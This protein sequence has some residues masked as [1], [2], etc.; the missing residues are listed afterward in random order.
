MLLV[1]VDSV[2]LHVAGKSVTFLP[3]CQTKFE[4]RSYAEGTSH[5]GIGNGIAIYVI[6]LVYPVTAGRA[7]GDRNIWAGTHNARSWAG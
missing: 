4:L 5:S 7:D 2:Y 1:V 3:W 6:C